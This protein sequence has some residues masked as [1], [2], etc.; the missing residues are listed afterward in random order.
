MQEQNHK[1]PSISIIT[2]SLNVEKTLR[3]CLDSVIAQNY[4][5]LEYWLIDGKSE[6]ST[7]DIINEY[8]S[9]YPFIKYISEKDTG[10]YNAINKGVKRAKGEWIYILGADDELYNED[11]LRDVFQKSN[12][13]EYDLVYGLFWNM[14]TNKIED[15]YKDITIDKFFLVSYSISQ[16]AFLLK[17]S[18]I[19]ELQYFDEN[20]RIGADTQFLYDCINKKGIKVL[21][22]DTI[23]AKY[24][25]S[26]IST[27]TNQILQ[28]NE[29]VKYL[30]HVFAT[31]SEQEKIILRDNL[32]SYSLNLNFV[33]PAILSGLKLFKI[34][35]DLMLI[36]KCLAQMVKRKLLSFG[37][38]AK[39]ASEDS[40]FLN[41]YKGTFWIGLLQ[42]FVLVYQGKNWIYIFKNALYWLRR[43]LND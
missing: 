31:S 34:I 17:K 5:N 1:Y 38:W 13:N 11:V 22:I 4:P 8:I 27:S 7:L 25:D 24:A 33:T 28:W 3:N 26:G 18:L 43:R 23:I 16:Q 32:I 9:Q 2:A 35:N 10:I 39:Y 20:Y 40:A 42:I 30:S 19:E 21:K 15:Y 29:C 14:R 41:I 37:F 12:L 6:D 36:D